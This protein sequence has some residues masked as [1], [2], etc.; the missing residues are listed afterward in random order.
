L[1]FDQLN[2]ATSLR[3]FTQVKLRCC[4]KAWAGPPDGFAAGRP[5]RQNGR[6]IAPIV[7]CASVGRFMSIPRRYRPALLA[8]IAALALYAIT[9]KGTYIEDDVIAI[10]E[11]PR[12]Y[13]PGQWRR[14]L[15]EE[16][17]YQGSV[18]H[19]YRPLVSLSYALQW[20][21]TGDNPL[22]FHA[23]NWLLNAAV[24]AMVAE[25]ARRLAGPA[26]SDGPAYLAGVLFGV[27]PIHVEAVAG[28]VGRAEMMCALGILGTIILLLRPRPI[29]VGRALAVVVC[30]AFAI[31]SKEQGMLLPLL[32]LLLPLSLGIDRPMNERERRAVMWLVVLVCWF[33]AAYVVWREWKFKFEWEIYFM[34]FSE[35]PMVRCS[36]FDRLLMP[37]VL[38]GHYA[39]LLV[40]PIHLSIDYGGRVIGWVVRRN[41][42]YLYAGV[43][44]ACGYI[45]TVGALIVRGPRLSRTSRSILFCLLA[46]GALYGMVGNIVSLIGTNFG[47]RL[48]YLPSMF[49]CVAA[50]FALMRLPRKVMLVFATIAIGLGSVRTVTYAREWNHRLRFYEISSQRQ[51][52]SVR[53]HM[54]VAVESLGRDRLAEAAAADR[55][56]RQSLPDYADVWIQSA[57]IAIAEHQF[58]EADRDLD[59]AMSLFPSPKVLGW[60]AEVAKARLAWK[61]GTSTKPGTQPTSLK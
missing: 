23:V 21:L 19:L 10:R 9:L 24:A 7:V 22:P 50:G 18:D 48:M 46:A 28:I 6:V 36:P 55:A 11:D 15:R 13:E 49:L 38:L 4:E 43:A 16:Y 42:P 14:L 58:D 61:A 12:L 52:M 34:D 33:T 31:F 3:L 41:D 35:Q 45:A 1:E 56:G 29:T 44:V 26:S 60:R 2:N 25:M 30:L 37:F 17:W 57:Q 5:A 54:L 53:L 59:E 47:E 8:A 39:Q 20:H 32:L 27:H 40:F 51:P